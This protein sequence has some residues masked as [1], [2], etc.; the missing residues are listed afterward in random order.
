MVRR[1]LVILRYWFRGGELRSPVVENAPLCATAP[2]TP[3]RINK[4]Q[5]KPK[6]FSNT[7]HVSYC[8]HL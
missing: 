4:T 1:G 6:H 5:T 8:K 7:P 3:A 2:T